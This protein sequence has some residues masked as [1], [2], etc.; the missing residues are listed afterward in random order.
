[1][2]QPLCQPRQQ[3]DRG[4]LFSQSDTSDS[5]P[6]TNKAQ[7]NREHTAMFQYVLPCGCAHWGEEALA[8]LKYQVNGLI[9]KDN[10]FLSENRILKRFLTLA[11]VNPTALL[12]SVWQGLLLPALSD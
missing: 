3:T 1:M 8:S 7:A 2:P 9:P 10:I 5:G 11:N 4:R 6:A 12:V